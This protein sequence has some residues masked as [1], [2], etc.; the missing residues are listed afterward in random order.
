MSEL[1]HEPVL[2]EFPDAQWDEAA[3]ALIAPAG[4]ARAMAQWL[5]G[6]GVDYC[7]NVTGVDYLEAEVKEK[8]TNE[9]GEVVVKVLA[10][11]YALSL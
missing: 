10:Q 8:V 1:S 11:A 7:S 3:C 9:A 6:Q 4:K 2:K 5:L